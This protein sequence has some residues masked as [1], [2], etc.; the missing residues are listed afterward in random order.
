MTVS[1]EYTFDT[2]GLETLLGLYKNKDLPAHDFFRYCMNEGLRLTRSPIGF[3]AF[4]NENETIL[5]I[6]SWSGSALKECRIEDKPL[7]YL[8]EKT[9]LWGALVWEKWTGA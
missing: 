9:G 6:Y 5:S 3:M 1:Q 7:V 4:V 2:A 8:A